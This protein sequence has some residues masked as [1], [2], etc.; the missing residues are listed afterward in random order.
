MKQ[1][2]YSWEECLKLRE[3]TSL[4][5]LNHANIVKL[6]EVWATLDVTRER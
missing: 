3:V 4:K 1:K 6:K 5:K 2:F